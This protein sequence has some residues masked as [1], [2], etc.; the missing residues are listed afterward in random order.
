M[1][2][3]YAYVPET[4]HK[5]NYKCF[6]RLCLIL[7]YNNALLVSFLYLFFSLEKPGD[8]THIVDIQFV[9]AMIQ[10]GGGRNDIPQ[11]LKRQFAIFNSCLPSNASIDKIFTTIGCGHFCE[12]RNNNL[13]SQFNNILWFEKMLSFYI[14]NFWSKFH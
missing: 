6:K 5:T 11:R 14:A 3:S 8:F 7:N 10:P 4:K 1:I 13:L 12:V 2:Q 9:V